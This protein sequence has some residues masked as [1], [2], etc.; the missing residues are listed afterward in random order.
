MSIKRGFERSDP[1]YWLTPHARTLSHIMAANAKALASIDAKYADR[2]AQLTEGEK[3]S[4][5][6]PYLASEPAL[7]RARLKARRLMLKYNQSSPSSYEPPDLKPGQKLR[8][9]F[10]TEEGAEE[11]VAPAGVAGEERQAILADLLGVPVSQLA[12]VEIEV[13]DAAVITR[14]RL[15]AF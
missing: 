12:D 2:L 9:A 13:G 5:G 14:S 4:L 15:V 6:L 11:E 10:A 1:I 3:A 8:G 7:V